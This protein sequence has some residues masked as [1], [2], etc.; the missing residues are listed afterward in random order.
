[1]DV[2]RTSCPYVSYLSHKAP[3]AA[4]QSSRMHTKTSQTPSRMQRWNERNAAI[5]N[6]RM[7]YR[8]LHEGYTCH[9][10][11]HSLSASFLV[12]LAPFLP[13]KP[14]NFSTPSTS[15][16]LSYSPGPLLACT[17][18]LLRPNS[19]SLRFPLRYSNLRHIL[20]WGY[21][22]RCSP[23]PEVGFTIALLQD[24]L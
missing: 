8:L 12:G 2:R 22:T 3:L 10:T 11:T 4:A 17:T 23:C 19:H 21:L 24:P 13:L 18:S 6:G 5:C 14:F 16:L 1:M 7:R 9:I 15:A 20:L